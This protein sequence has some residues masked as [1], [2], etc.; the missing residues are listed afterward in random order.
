LTSSS[1]PWHIRASQQGRISKEGAGKGP[2][3]AHFA[4]KRKKQPIISS[5]TA[6][7]PKKSGRK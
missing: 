4:V 6:I 1:G 2:L 5:L 7:T 3:D